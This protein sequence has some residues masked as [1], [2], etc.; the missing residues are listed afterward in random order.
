MDRIGG[1]PENRFDGKNR[2]GVTSVASAVTSCGRWAKEKKAG[3]LEREGQNR[4]H[5]GGAQS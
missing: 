2:P 1:F 3:G 5:L 4:H